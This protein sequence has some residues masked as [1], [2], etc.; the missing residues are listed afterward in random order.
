MTAGTAVV[1]CIGMVC[2]TL[3]ALALIG[4]ANNRKQKQATDKITDAILK[5]INKKL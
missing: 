5:N 2:A 1:I 4:A 3:I